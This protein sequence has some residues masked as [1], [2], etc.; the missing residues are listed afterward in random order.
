M[1]DAGQETPDHIPDHMELRAVEL[2]TPDGV[3]K[4]RIAVTR[5]QMGLSGLVRTAC[6]LTDGL[7]A[8]AVQLERQAG[9]ALTC[10]A[11]CG[12]CC[13]HMVP[14]SPPEAIHLVETIESLGSERRGKAMDAFGRV[15]AVLERHRLIADLFDPPPTDE[16]I[17]PA[18]RKYFELGLACPFLR[19]G[20]CVIHPQRPIACRDYNV[21]S[22]ADWCD[23]PYDKD[24][25]KIPM[26]MPLSVSLARLTAKLTGDRPCLIPLTLAPRWVEQNQVLRR[27]NW[28]GLELFDRF[29]AEIGASPGDADGD[30]LRAT[31]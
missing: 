10:A 25:A 3:V 15:I 1:T 12:A 24:V 11:G 19:N 28:P 22:P 30:R 21:S 29:L 16:P 26:P 31:L 4:G 20:S 13:R 2:P 27:R 18:A 14:V 5:G 7:V 6:A 9:R 8:R 23:T 17:L